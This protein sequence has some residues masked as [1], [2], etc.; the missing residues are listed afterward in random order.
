VQKEAALQER[1]KSSAEQFKL[2]RLKNKQAI[3]TAKSNRPSLIE[4]QDQAVAKQAAGTAS[5]SKVANAFIRGKTATGG[6][7]SKSDAW[8]ELAREEDFLDETEKIKLGLRDKNFQDDLD[9]FA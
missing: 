5:L 1:V 6:A 2:N 8:Q 7:A 9:E 3:E 4:R